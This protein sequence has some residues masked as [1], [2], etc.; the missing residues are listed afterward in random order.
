MVS[1][2]PQL[3]VFTCRMLGE[4]TTTLP[5]RHRSTH[6]EALGLR[7]APPGPRTCNTFGPMQDRGQGRA[8]QTGQGANRRK[9]HSQA[10]PAEAVFA[11][12]E[13][14]L[15]KGETDPERDGDPTI[16]RLGT[17]G[18]E[19]STPEHL[20]H[21]HSSRAGGLRTTQQKQPAVVY[22]TQQQQPAVVCHVIIIIIII[23]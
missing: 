6:R 16:Q 21:S 10:G 18:G 2:F 4:R 7:G 19:G 15:E 9:T 3:H 17:K 8:W 13:D 11:P 1:F 20:V 14:Y 12:W 5:P 23:M 22:T